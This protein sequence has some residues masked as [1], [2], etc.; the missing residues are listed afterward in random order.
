MPP[1]KPPY[2]ILKEIET[3]L[4]ITAWYE[5]VSL[6]AKYYERCIVLEK[7]RDLWRDKYKQLK[8]SLKDGN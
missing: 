4:G 5:M 1:S 2:K 7:S 8:E 3:K 6:L